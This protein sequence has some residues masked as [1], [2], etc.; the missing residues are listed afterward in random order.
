[1][2]KIWKICIYIFLACIFTKV[3]HLKFSIS[4][5]MINLGGELGRGDELIR[6]ELEVR[7]GRG[8]C[9]HIHIL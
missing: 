4:A 5:S 6:L 2:K 3:I 8:H 9:F 1:M 7:L